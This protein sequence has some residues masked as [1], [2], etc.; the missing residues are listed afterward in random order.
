MLVI[1]DMDMAKSRGAR[2]YARIAGMGESVSVNE[3]VLHLEA[4][5]KGLEIAITNAIEEAGITPDKLD[6]I[7]PHGTAI[8]Q[9]DKAEAAAMEAALG[10]ALGSIPVLPTKSMLGH[11]G[12][13][14]A[15]IDLVIAAMAMQEGVIPAAKNCDQAFEGCKLNIVKEKIE[16]DINYALCCSYTPGGQ[17]V[18]IVLEKEGA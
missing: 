8:A 18:A 12:T 6:L 7:I 11:T 4:D 1:E 16:K 9:D 10:E 3:D 13:A 2:I 14:S 17:C 15:S 5:G